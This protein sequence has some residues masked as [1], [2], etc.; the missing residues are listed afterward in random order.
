MLGFQ[1]NSNRGGLLSGRPS[2]TG[3]DAVGLTNGYAAY[4]AMNESG[5]NK[6]INNVAAARPHYFHFATAG[7]GGGSPSVTLLPPLTIPGASI[8]LQYE[9]E[10]DTPVIDF[11]PQTQPLPAGLTLAANQFA[12]AT[13]VEICV[14]CN[15]LIRKRPQRSPLVCG[16]LKLW[17]IGHPTSIAVNATD[18][19]IGLSA[20]D[21][22][23]E[24]IGSIESLAECVAKDALNA[25]LQNMQYLVAKHVFGAFSFFLADGPTIDDNQLKVW[26]GIG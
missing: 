22:V 19:L 20:D 25:L 2:G 10:V 16:T 12:I 21:I 7:L 17:A 8:G 13:G 4:A 24:D 11:Y 5:F 1:P 14:V 26:G 6:F 15:E 23:I 9:I 3:G 18:K